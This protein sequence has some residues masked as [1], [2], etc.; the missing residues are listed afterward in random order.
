MY[1]KITVHEMKFRAENL[2]EGSETMIAIR[3]YR[4]EN[5]LTQYELAKKCGVAQSTVAMW[6]SGERKPDVIKLK[7]LSCILG[8]SA[9]D[10]LATI[11]PHIVA[12]TFY[13]MMDE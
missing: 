4:I 7:E 5:G 9:D 6:E 2:Y 12:D 1:N 3:K 13:E 8:C 10:L 11:K